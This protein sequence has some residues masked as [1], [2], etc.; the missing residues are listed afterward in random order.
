MNKYLKYL[1]Y[2]IRHKWYVFKA[3]LRWGLIWRGLVHDL[4]KFLPSEI[5]P[6]ANWFRGEYGLSFSPTLSDALTKHAIW[7]LDL[8]YECKRAF[9]EAWLFHQHRNPHHWQYWLLRKDDG[10]LQAMEMPDIYVIEMVADWVGAG[11][12]LGKPDTWAWWKANEEKIHLH[13]NTKA[14]V[15][16]LLKGYTDDLDR[17]DQED[18]DPAR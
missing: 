15:I 5:V 6:Y 16:T 2:V 17:S 18:G 12:A 14:K 10:S 7:K 4:S 11:T 1:S 9:D 3:C 13:L 8:H